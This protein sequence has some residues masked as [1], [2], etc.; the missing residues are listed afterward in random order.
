M[1]RYYG[2]QG[3]FLKLGLFVSSHAGWSSLAFG[4]NGGMKGAQQPLDWGQK[5][6]YKWRS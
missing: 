3:D 2:P 5:A 6:C 4:G 1:M